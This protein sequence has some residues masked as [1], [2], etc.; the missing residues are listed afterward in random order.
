[1][2]SPILISLFGGIKLNPSSDR[3]IYLQL[4]DMILALI[5]QGKLGSDQKL[6][7][8]RAVADLL[9]LN[10]LTVTKAYAELQMQ[11]WLESF[12]GKGTFVST[13]VPEIQPKQLKSTSTTKGQKQAGFALDSKSYRKNPFFVSTA[14]LHLDHGY[15]DPTL[16]PLKELYR[17]Y[18]TQLSCESRLYP[19][20]GSYGQPDGADFYKEALSKYLNETRGLKTTHRNILSTRGT[21]MGINLVCSALI[22]PGDVVVSGI[23]GWQRLE[24]NFIHSWANHI[25]IPVDENGIVVDELRKICEKRKVRMVYIT[26]HHHYP[27]TVSLSID[28]RLELL[29]LAKEFGFIIFEDD[30]DF[31]FHYNH[32]PLLPL[33]SADDQ[34]MV[35]YGGSFSK[36]ISPAFRVGYLVAPENVIE[37]LSNT[38]MLLDRQGDHILD[39]AMAELLNDGTIT[40]YLRK[41]LAVYEKRRNHFCDLLR[42]ELNNVVDFV[43]PEG[44]MTV[45]T[46]FDKSINLSELS[47]QAYEKNLYISDGLVHKYPDYDENAIRL[48]FASSTIEELSESVNILK[49][50]IFKG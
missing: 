47:T 45:W 4:A 12:V 38:R 46:T 7:S 23:P 36:S 50:L 48:G 16:A 24:H 29:A 11:G 34:G 25:G 40:R 20:F 1:M 5:K 26:P 22:K 6:P 2:S 32:R 44:G 10:R 8:S 42:S 43:V 21:I 28:R 18:R 27:T 37:H 41:A 14:R 31:D 39:N 3:A 17:A 13:H 49:S 30:Y 33:I 19:R 9:S 35:I 15:P